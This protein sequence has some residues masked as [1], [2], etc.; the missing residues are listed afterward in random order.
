MPVIQA[1]RI[2]K[3]LTTNKVVKTTKLSK[4]VVGSKCRARGER[5]LNHSASTHYT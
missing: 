4:V 5:F 1:K 2:L 3:Q